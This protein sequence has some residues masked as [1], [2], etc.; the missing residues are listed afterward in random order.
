VD[1]DRAGLI[2]SLLQM[3]KAAQLHSITPDQGSLDLVKDSIHELFN[4][5]QI[6]MLILF[7]DAPHQ[8]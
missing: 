8:S 5:A 7:L 6:Q 4:V 3:P 1:R 2:W